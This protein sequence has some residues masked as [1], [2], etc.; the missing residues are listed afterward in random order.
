M[1]GKKLGKNNSVIVNHGDII[2][3]VC[4]S[5]GHTLS[6]ELPIY[7]LEMVHNKPQEE[8][9]TQQNT[10]ETQ[11]FEDVASTTMDTTAEGDNELKRKRNDENQ[12]TTT[13][14][15]PEQKQ[16]SAKKQKKSLSEQDKKL[17]ALLGATDS[18]LEESQEEESEMEKEL[19]CCICSTIFYK[20]VSVIPC[21]HNFCSS[22][23]SQWINSNRNN[24]FGPPTHQCPTCRSDITEVRKNPQLNNLT[25]S[26]LKTNPKKERSKE[27]KEDLDKKDN[28]LGKTDLVLYKKNDGGSRSRATQSDDDE[29]SEEED[30]DD[31]SPRHRQCPECINASAIDGYR[32]ATN[33]LHLSCSTCSCLLAFRLMD[34]TLPV[35]RRLSCELC[36]AVHCN[37]YKQTTNTNDICFVAGI[38]KLKEHSSISAIPPTSMNNNQYERDILRNYMLSKSI[39]AQDVYNSCMTKLESGAYTLPNYPSVTAD[40]RLC[41][42]CA[43]RVFTDLVYNYRADIPQT[44][45]PATVTSRP[46]CWYGRECRTQVHNHG[47]AQRFN[48]ICEIRNRQ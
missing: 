31:E 34:T 4:P 2:G 19:T 5:V 11:V 17:L 32:C 48:H 35:D 36:N 47:H 39:S 33:A 6:N 16:D 40:S 28:F 30:S 38:H 20:P 10:Q 18:D 46:N 1:N 26:F 22:C 15:E 43:C 25:E 45:L 14:E 12:E 3:L 44:E 37:L 41:K 8:Q 23:L 24:Y 29:S 13:E 27:E 42:S 21:L 9:S 7:R